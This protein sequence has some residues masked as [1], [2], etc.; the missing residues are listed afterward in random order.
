MSEGYKF[1]DEDVEKIENRA[2]IGND[3]LYEITFKS[4]VEAFNI[5]KND[6]IRLARL[7][8]LAVYEADSSL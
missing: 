2:N 3:E 7:F 8:G 1:W 6:V 4:P 5:H